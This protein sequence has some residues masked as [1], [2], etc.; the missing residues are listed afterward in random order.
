MC[1]KMFGVHIKGNTKNDKYSVGIYKKND[2]R[3]KELVGNV[4]VAFSSLV[5]HFQVLKTVS[6]LK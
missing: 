6:T 2:D 3:S 5:C 1:I 4:V